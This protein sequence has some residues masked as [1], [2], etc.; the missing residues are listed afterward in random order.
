MKKAA[1][2]LSVILILL[3]AIITSIALFSGIEEDNIRHG[4]VGACMGTLPLVAYCISVVRVCRGW[5]LTAA[6]L[7]GLY[8]A[9]VVVL[10]MGIL[11]NDPSTMRKLLSVLLV[12]LVP[13]VLNMLA[14]VRMR[15]SDPRLMPLPDVPG[16][17]GGKNVEGLGGWLIIV[18][19]SVVLSPFLIATKAYKSYSEMSLL[20]KAR[21]AGDFLQREAKAEGAGGHFWHDEVLTQTP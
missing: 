3:V 14:L 8:F 21:F 15:Q 13:L 5:Y 9:L 4:I 19:V 6:A 16:V 1:F 12:L 7:N 20:Q 17:A 18:G 2:V 10:V 11:M